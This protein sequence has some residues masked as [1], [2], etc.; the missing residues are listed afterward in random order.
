MASMKLVYVTIPEM[1]DWGWD[2]MEQ[3]EVA[4]DSGEFDSIDI[5]FYPTGIRME[6]S[7]AVKDGRFE[8][9]DIDD[10]Y[11]YRQG[12]GEVHSFLREVVNAESKEEFFRILESH[13]TDFHPGHVED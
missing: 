1:Q 5:D 4:H 7:N 13:A 8:L 12:R 2:E 3:A 10:V 9:G 11:S 6:L